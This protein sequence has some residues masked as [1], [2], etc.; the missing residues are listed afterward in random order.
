MKVLKV[1]IVTNKLEYHRFTSK[2]ISC[3]VIIEH[4]NPFTYLKLFSLNFK[5]S[6]F[7]FI[8]LRLP[9]VYLIKLLKNRCSRLVVLQH[10]FNENNNIKSFSYFLNNAVK[11]LMWLFSILI[12][13]LFLYKI[14]YNTKTSCYYFTDYYRKRL[15]TIVKNVLYH[16][17]GE[18]DPLN[19]GSKEKILIEDQIINYFYVDEPLTRTLGISLS[20][21]KKLISDLITEFHI[22]KLF[23]KLHPRSSKEKFAG[24]PNIV[25]T[26]SIYSNSKTLIGYKS[27]L[28]R[29]PFKSEKFIELSRAKL[30]W[31]IKDYNFSKSGSYSNDVKNNIKKHEI[32]SV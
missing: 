21:E 13:N 16:K 25:L 2:I 17:C 32:N 7:Y 8:G 10:A 22:N 11:F 18:P 12:T 14:K 20:R 4:E 5:K 24:L 31:H 30:S 3:D 1:A 15:N 27:N 29:H 28:L 9:D 26:D 6:E 19:F 23:V